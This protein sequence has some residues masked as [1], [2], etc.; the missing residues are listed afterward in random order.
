MLLE[1][2]MSQTTTWILV[3]V[4][5]AMLLLYILYLKHKKS[6]DTATSK[7]AKWGT[8]GAYVFTSLF[9]GIGF[10]VFA[11]GRS[12]F[13]Q[14]WHEHWLGL[15]LSAIGCVLSAVQ[16][17]GKALKPDRFRAPDDANVDDINVR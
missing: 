6:V 15:L 17:V 1:E 2:S 4:L 13:Y 10:Y 5:G 9:F 14:A 8:V 7:Y 16:A 11:R 12:E 3:S